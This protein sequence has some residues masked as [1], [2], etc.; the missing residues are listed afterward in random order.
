MA[1][2]LASICYL[3]PIP[4]PFCRVWDPGRPGILLGVLL[5]STARIWSS[6]PTSTQT[7]NAVKA[8]KQKVSPTLSQ[9]H[10]LAMSYNRRPKYLNVI[11]G[12]A[13]ASL[14]LPAVWHSSYLASQTPFSTDFNSAVCKTSLPALPQVPG[15]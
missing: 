10:T 6:G 9:H 1:L 15:L 2:P 13:G 4:P 12:G 8:P 11:R 3:T 7:K 14:K 5:L